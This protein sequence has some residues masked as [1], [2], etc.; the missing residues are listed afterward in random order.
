MTY[1]DRAPGPENTG[2][3]RGKL[4]GP[5]ILTF[6]IRVNANCLPR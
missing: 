3:K 2:I 1:E 4:T 5:I 6:R